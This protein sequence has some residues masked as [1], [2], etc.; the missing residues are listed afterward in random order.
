MRKI[1]FGV[2]DLPFLMR[3]STLKLVVVLFCIVTS[4]ND[5][6]ENDPAINNAFMAEME[7]ARVKMMEDMNAVTMTMD[8]DVDFANM[9]IPHHQGSIDMANILLKFGEHPEALELARGAMEADQESQNR[10][11][12]FL[13]EHG[14]PVPQA[15]HDFMEEMDIVMM[16]MDESMKAM[17]YTIDPDYDFAEMMIH[18]HQGAIDMSRVEFKYGEAEMALEEAKRI[19]EHQEKEIIELARFRSKH[20]PS[21]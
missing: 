18:H 8:P 21:R 20:G 7:A 10:L 11:R 6:G 3:F 14:D 17:H 16:K 2:L 5:L 1:S 19:I 9:M 15:V 12:Q 13:E 4:C